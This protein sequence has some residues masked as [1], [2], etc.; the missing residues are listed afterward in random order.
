MSQAMRK[1]TGSIARSETL[2]IFI[3]QIREKVGVMFGS[4][5]TTTGGR[6]L[7]FYASVRIDIRRIGQLKEGEVVV[8]NRTKV[9][10]VKN[11]I[12]PPFRK[13]EFDIL[14]NQ[15]ISMEGDLLDM[16]LE[17][18]VVLKS[19]PGSP[20][21]TP[22]RRGAPRPGPRE[23]APVPDRQPRPGRAARGGDPRKLAPPPA[24]RRR[25]PPRRPRPPRRP[26]PGRSAAPAPNAHPTDAPRAKAAEATAVK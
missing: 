2:V 4:P 25:P 24:R 3:N 7:K 19:G 13:V 17:Q 12:A 6:A 14:Y 20:S 5:E 18:G 11:K 8:G 21:S 1:L 26:P 9:T 15:G 10:V 23:G 22:R 16:G